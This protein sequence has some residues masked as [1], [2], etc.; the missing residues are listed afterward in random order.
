MI[1]PCI[2]F[3]RWLS[4]VTQRNLA[5]DL[6]QRCSFAIHAMAIVCE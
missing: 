4:V 5:L 6:T 2:L 1:M 3:T